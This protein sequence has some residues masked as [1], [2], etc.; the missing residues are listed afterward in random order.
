M[1]LNPIL[2]QRIIL[3]QKY[4]SLHLCYGPDWY[5][6]VSIPYPTKQQLRLGQITSNPGQNGQ[7]FRVG[8]GSEKTKN[9]YICISPHPSTRRLFKFILKKNKNIHIIK[10]Q[11][12]DCWCLGGTKST[13]IGE[14]SLEYSGLST[15]RVSQL[16]TRTLN[17]LQDISVHLPLD[18]LFRLTLKNI[19]ARSAS[20]ALPGESP[21]DRWILSLHK[22]PITR[23]TFPC[24]DV[25]IRLQS[26]ERISIIVVYLPV[27]IKKIKMKVIWL[28][29]LSNVSVKHDIKLQANKSFYMTKYKENIIV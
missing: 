2:F 8:R 21:G 9:I 24:H 29:R 12:N 10:S 5:P 27:A 20:L 19:K 11:Y 18:R 16:I 15:C 17:E 1:D 23:K 26:P 28:K 25:M 14:V 3:N 22:G 13:G 6:I 4:L 7:H